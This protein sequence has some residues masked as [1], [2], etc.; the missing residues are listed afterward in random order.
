MNPW[1]LIQR[2]TGVSQTRVQPRSG[3]PR[4]LQPQTVNVRAT[5]V[6]GAGAP[7]GLVP[8]LGM[9]GFYADPS[10]RAVQQRNADFVIDA[11]RRALAPASRAPAANGRTNVDPLRRMTAPGLAAPGGGG[12]DFRQLG[13]WLTKPRLTPEQ[14]RRTTAPGLS[15]VSPSARFD[16]RYTATGAP[17]PGMIG[18]GNVAGGGNA[19]ASIQSPMSGIAP[20][21]SWTTAVTPGARAR[22][23]RMNELSQQAGGQNYSFETAFPNEFAGAKS[24]APVVEQYR[25]DLAADPLANAPALIDQRSQEYGQR[26]DIAK[27]MEANRNAPKGADGMNVVDRFLAKQRPAA[28]SLA[29]SPVFNSPDADR[30]VAEAGYGGMKYDPE[31]TKQLQAFE[32]GADWA[33][34][35]GGAMKDAKFE[36]GTMEFGG[37]AL[38]ARQAPNR[39]VAE[40]GYQGMKVDP[41]TAPEMGT[42]G[43]GSTWT[44]QGV[45][46]LQG[47]PMTAAT[48]ET[49]RQINFEGSPLPEANA[50]QAASKEADDLLE[51]YK[52][53]ILGFGS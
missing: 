45:N 53:N 37:D 52:R 30:Q 19:G 32:A 15:T 24:A 11:S 6:R 44:G 49:N 20:G 33:A 3:P 43:A 26:A 29:D 48:A 42:L 50:A 39:A 31:S 18:S 5:A 14:M 35:G 1:D 2:A 34:S 21:S 16:R 17:I 23:E 51:V 10:V 13:S 7:R 4:G 47:M 38:R 12:I 40:A 25:K 22:T 28:Q 46:Q 41:A 36:Q 8:G 27:W 9:A